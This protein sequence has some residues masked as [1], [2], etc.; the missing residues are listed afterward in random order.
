MEAFFQRF[1]DA[2]DILTAEGV[3]RKERSKQPP[4]D[5]GD[6]LFGGDLPA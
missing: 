2:Y 5:R 4:R 1:V 6:D 3:T